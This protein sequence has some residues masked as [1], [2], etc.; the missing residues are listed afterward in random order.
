MNRR[1]RT[2]LRRLLKAMPREDLLLVLLGYA[3]GLTDA[4]IAE[5]LGVDSA[6]VARHKAE[7]VF[8]LRRQFA[9]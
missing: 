2:K 7:I 6:A 9:G 5:L 4:E 8:E 3:D 1:L